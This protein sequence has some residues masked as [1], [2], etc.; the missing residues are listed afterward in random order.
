MPIF[1]MTNVDPQRRVLVLAAIAP[2]LLASCGKPNPAR[3]NDAQVVARVNDADI[4]VHQVQALLQRPPTALQEQG[5]ASARRVLDQL[6]EQELAAQAAREHEMDRDPGVVQALEAARREVLARAWQ[7]RLAGTARAATSDEIDRYYADHPALFAQ[8]RLYTLQETLV[9]L[10]DADV[11]RVKRL[12]SEARG[13]SDLEDKLASGRFRYR[14]RQ[15]A[16]AAEDLPLPLL[17]PLA[18]LADNDS[19]TIQ[20]G[21]VLRIYTVLHAELAPVN[22]RAATDPIAVYL[23]LERKRAAVREGMQ[24]LRTKARVEYRGSFAQAA[25]S[26]ASGAAAR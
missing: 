23:H 7:D 25:S 17:D 22:R 13:P 24:N 2:L 4:T 1:P 6:V 19:L 16:Q 15:I 12:A 5:D 18:R 21:D 10:R 14:T 3:M 9:D 11:L 26:P 8:R 20:Q